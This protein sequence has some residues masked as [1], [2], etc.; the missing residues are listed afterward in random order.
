MVYTPEDGH[1]SQ[2][3]HRH[4][5]GKY[6]DTR[7]LVATAADYVTTDHFQRSQSQDGG[8]HELLLACCCLQS[9]AA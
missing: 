5:V 4:R 1:P 8:P 2:K 6:L 3:T 9:E 7:R